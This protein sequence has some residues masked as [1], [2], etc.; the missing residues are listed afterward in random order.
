MYEVSPLA[1]LSGGGS[2]GGVGDG[3]I[4]VV[5]GGGDLGVKYRLYT[6]TSCHFNT[7]HERVQ[8]YEEKTNIAHTFEVHIHK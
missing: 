4:F 5:G 3:G 1:T 2:G 7:E 8:T 6:A